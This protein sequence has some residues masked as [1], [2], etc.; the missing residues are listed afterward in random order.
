MFA[1]LRRLQADSAQK[2]ETLARD[3]SN[4]TITFF[5]HIEEELGGLPRELLS[6]PF[7]IGLA[8]MYAALVARVRSNGTAPMRVV[9][10]AMIMSIQGIFARHGCDRIQAIGALRN[11]KNTSECAAGHRAADLIF[12]TSLQQK[13]Y[14]TEPEVQAAKLALGQMSPVAR[15]AFFGSIESDQVAGMLSRTLVLDRL[16]MRYVKQPDAL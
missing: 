12:G 16:A 3:A 5:S 2:A 11:S 15:E 13:R 14:D 7:V 6:D 10:S 4:S 8:S 9:E 1:W